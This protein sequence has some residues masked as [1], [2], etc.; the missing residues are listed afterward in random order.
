MVHSTVIEHDTKPEWKTPGHTDPVAN[1]MNNH[2]E[3]KHEHTH[4]LNLRKI[5]LKMT[6]QKIFRKSS[7]IT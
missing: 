3:N 4:K 6:I 7:L 5:T 2:V 1:E